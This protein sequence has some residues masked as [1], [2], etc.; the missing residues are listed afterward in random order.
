[1]SGLVI[2]EGLFNVNPMTLVSARLWRSSRSIT[3][4]MYLRSAAEAMVESGKAIRLPSKGVLG[5]K[6]AIRGLV[7][8][9]TL[10]KGTKLTDYQSTSGYLDD[11]VFTDPAVLREIDRHFARRNSVESVGDFWKWFDG[12][13]STWKGT[14]LAII[15]AFH[16]RNFVDS[17][18]RLYLAGVTRSSII[19][20]RIMLKH[21][22]AKAH[23][24]VTGRKWDEW[25]DSPLTLASGEVTTHRKLVD[26]AQ[27]AGVIGQQI[28]GAE[29]LARDPDRAI[30]A[31][32][33]GEGGWSHTVKN[34]VN[35]N[36]QENSVIK[37]GYDIGRKMIE[38]PVR[39]AQYFQRRIE[40][41]T[42]L[43]AMF[44]VKKYHFDY[45]DLSDFEKN[46]LRRV[47]PFY[48]FM[49]FNIPLQIETVLNKPGKVGKL[50]IW[51]RSKVVADALG[52]DKRDVEAKF[53]TDWQRE[54]APFF[55]GR[56]PNNPDRA[57]FLMMD[58][59]LSTADLMKLFDP[60]KYFG[61]LTPVLR[62]PI[63]QLANYDFFFKK[64]LTAMSN[65]SDSLL[66]KED[67]LNMSVP[68][69]LVHLLRNIR[70]FNEL[71]RTIKV[72]SS[73]EK[74]AQRLFN[75]LARVGVGSPLQLVS[76]QQ[77]AIEIGFRIRKIADEG[78]KAYL[79][80]I[81]RGRYDEANDLIQATLARI[82]RGY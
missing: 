79:K 3:G 4:A 51:E 19:R 74:G 1:M 32:M 30:K 2:K 80:A 24:A 28:E 46:V 81:R 25:M 9:G 67:F 77:G 47:M 62:E 14:Q 31:A 44:D 78:R 36:A 68:R 75:T 41:N 73:S 39:L 5:R 12:A 16:S 69:R 35:L 82:S 66:E 27:Q 22:G 33:R 40:G 64:P 48:S 11:F 76:E 23:D 60:Q 43:D 20:A 59:W 15:P 34:M 50:F 63:S 61:D 29:F 65:F 49:R 17:H 71:D 55:M 45:E 72:A 18:W 56:D 37:M 13:M 70:M 53:L 21:F 7:D 52:Q 57:R 54:G 6:A 38:D 58:G 26:E 10:M 42:I 8:N